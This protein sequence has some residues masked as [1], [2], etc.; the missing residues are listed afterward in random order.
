MLATPEKKTDRYEL[1]EFFFGGGVTL[2]E[3]LRRLGQSLIASVRNVATIR[4]LPK[5]SEREKES[6][7]LLSLP[8]AMLS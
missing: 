3:Q 8:F 1:L 5:G 2:Q 7:L 6:G 4:G